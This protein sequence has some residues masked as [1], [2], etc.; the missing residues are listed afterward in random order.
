VRQAEHED[1]EGVVLC[2]RLVE[3]VPRAPRVVRQP[4]HERSKC[5]RVHAEPASELLRLVAIPAHDSDLVPVSRVV[6]ADGPQT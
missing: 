4:V 1:A 5:R 3:G 6:V 2:Q